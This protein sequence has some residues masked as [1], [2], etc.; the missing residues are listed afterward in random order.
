MKPQSAQLQYMRGLF[1]FQAELVH[2]F[3]VR[4]SHLNSFRILYPFQ[5][6]RNSECGQCLREYVC[7]MLF[8]TGKWNIPDSF[9]KQNT[10]NI[11]FETAMIALSDRF[12]SWNVLEWEGELL[13]VTERRRN[14]N[15]FHTGLLNQLLDSQAHA[16]RFNCVYVWLYCLCS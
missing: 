7:R 1:R 8:R 12:P 15:W 6:K 16:G 13:P 10:G 9:F 3:S 2:L 5:K 11:P 4:T 14:H